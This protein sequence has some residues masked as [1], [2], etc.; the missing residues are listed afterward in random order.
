MGIEFINQDGTFTLDNPQENSY[1]YFPV[2]NEAPTMGNVA[3]DFR[4]DSKLDQNTFMLEP[5]SPENLHSSMSGRNFWCQIEGNIP[6]SATGESMWQQMHS[7]D[8]ALGDQTKLTAGKLWQR[9]QRKNK[10]IG[11]EADVR[12]FCPATRETAELMSVTI[13]NS[14]EQ[15]KKITPIVAIPVYGRS[16][17]NIRDHRHVTS[18]LGRTTLEKC[19]ITVKPTLSFDERGH[20]KNETTYS[21]FA[22]GESGELPVGFYPVVE[23]FIG[24]GG[25]FFWPKAVVDDQVPCQTE[26]ETE[27]YEVMGGIRFAQVTLQP[28]ESRTYCV[29]LSYNRSGMEY[30][31]EKKMEAAFLDAKAFWKNQEIIRCESGDDAFDQWMGWVSIQ[32]TLRRIYGCSFMPHHDYGRGGRGWR[33]LWQDSLALILLEPGEVRGNLISY[34]G[35][36][37]MDGTNATIIGNK[38]GEFKADRNAIPRVWMDHGLWPLITTNLYIQQTGDTSILLEENTYF[39]EGEYQ[40]TVENQPYKGSVLE[41]ILIQHLASFYDVGM[42]NHIRLRGADWNDGL[43]MAEE[44]GESVAFTAAYSGNLLTLARLAHKLRTERE[45][46]EVFL[47]EEVLQL[48]RQPATMYNSVGQKTEVLKQYRRLVS[49]PLS[50]H[51]VSV[52]LE[53]LEEDLKSKAE[54]IQLNIRKKELVGDSAGNQWFN[55]YYDNHCNQVEGVINGNVRMMLTGQVFTIM[56]GTASDEQIAAITKAADEYLYEERMGGYRLNTNFHEVKA[57]MGRMFGFAYGH[58]ENGAVFSH[59]A[60]MYAYSLYQKG[61]VKEGYKAL[62]ALYRQGM[63]FESS[64]IYPGIPEYYNER[65]RGCYHYLTGAASWYVFTVLTEMYG[66]KGVSGDLQIHP[67]LLA[68]QFDTDGRAAICCTFAGRSLKV[69]YLNEAH[70]EIGDYEIED[71]R[72]DGT[73]YEVNE[74]ECP[75]IKRSVI[76]QLDPAV[77][78]EIKV[79]LG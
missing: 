6:W 19:G 48:L 61:F 56:S 45:L 27:G 3:P 53:E 21:I 55:G 65:G 36:V 8:A 39:H 68:E 57:D 52:R 71:I 40:Q 75:Q 54:W 24:E 29:V 62:N 7:K 2:A 50:G 32:P 1:L 20:K 60:V 41:H 67:K 5:V 47:A 25:S 9:V 33:D 23:D 17:D 66:V 16:A 26:G 76:E 59:M 37:R 58:K 14:G 28:G 18:L 13:C 35:G 64:H 72:I 12:Y 74:V 4:G 34:F 42:H 15:E 78:H 22:S 31:E 38:P 73:G 44:N 77:P 11:I 10:H 30:L 63:N 43:D 69:V 79:I 70:K 51:K 49:R 46:Q